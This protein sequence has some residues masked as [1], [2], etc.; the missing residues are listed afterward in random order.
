MFEIYGPDTIE[1]PAECEESIRH[2]LESEFGQVCKEHGG[3]LKNGNLWGYF[4]FHVRGS[5][6][7]PCFVSGRLSD[8]S[9]TERAKRELYLT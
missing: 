3:I 5:W 4:T 1:Y 2:Y 8:L 7:P 9:K 6:Y